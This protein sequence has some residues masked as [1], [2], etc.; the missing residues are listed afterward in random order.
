MILTVASMGTARSAPAMPHIQYQK[1]SETMTSTG[2]RMNRRASSRGV[3]T[4][5]SA[6]W[7]REIDSGEQ[8]GLP[9]EV[10]GQEPGEEQKHHAAERPQDRHEIQQE[11]HGAPEDGVRKAA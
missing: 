11:G 7:M 6:I 4:S 3:T 9:D 5:P 8:H 1:K 2:L 10:E